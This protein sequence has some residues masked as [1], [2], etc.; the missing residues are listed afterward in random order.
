MYEKDIR[1]TLGLR[2]NESKIFAIESY[3]NL[4]KEFNIY[5]SGETTSDKS[6]F[7]LQ[8]AHN[9]LEKVANMLDYSMPGEDISQQEI[10]DASQESYNLQTSLLQVKEKL[11]DLQNNYQTTT[12]TQQLAVVTKE[13]MIAIAQAELNKTLAWS[14]D[15]Q[16]LAQQQLDL[17]KAQQDE[18]I[19]QKQNSIAISQAQLNQE[20]ATSANDKV[21]SPF[22]GVVSKRM[23]AV[24]DIVMMSAPMFELI[25]VNTSLA[26][27]SK[28]E[29]Q[30]GL[31]EEYRSLVLVGKEIS[32]TLPEDNT[33][34]HL[35]I[36]TRIAP[37][38]DIQTHTIT[39]QAKISDDLTLPHH[40]RVN[41]IIDLDK[42]INYSIPSTS[43]I[44][45]G[46]QSFITTLSGDQH[47][48]IIPITVIADDG[49]FADIQWNID[50][51][52][53]VILHPNRQRILE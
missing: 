50:E 27:K 13:S 2:N 34:K 4:K 48:I 26:K 16:K 14:A 21:L 6:I 38:V 41:V 31:P 33:Q 11:E 37:Q 32:F 46:Q 28:R 42:Q 35:A 40:T 8:T 24:G 9:T 53:D 20:R 7:I 12:Q 17:I 49:E 47:L 25:D 19:K 43:I 1:I 30:F 23:I 5:N 15:A 3:R 10:D 22:R 18:K 45:S 36:V 51:H 29:V 44:Y 52:M 39:I